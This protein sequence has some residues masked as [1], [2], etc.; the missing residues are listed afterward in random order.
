MQLPVLR[1]GTRGGAL[2]SREQETMS[3]PPGWNSTRVGTETCPVKDA[4][5]AADGG[6]SSASANSCG[7]AA[8][9]SAPKPAV[10]WPSRGRGEGVV[11]G[12]GAPGLL[13]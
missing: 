4:T 13:A 8:V 12:R 3:E 11:V 6:S 7:N 10:R 1:R 9:R 2:P 5:M